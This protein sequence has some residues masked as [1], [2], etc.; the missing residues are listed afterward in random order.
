V[1]TDR[2]IEVLAGRY[3][4]EAELGRGATGAVWVAADDLLKRTVAVKVL[5]PA[6]ADDP[7]S[8]ELLLRH[9]GAAAGASGPGLARLLDSGS[10]RGVTYL[11]RE[12]IPGES[13]RA[14]LRR[15]GPLEPADA[16]RSVVQALE[17]LA[18]AHAAGVLH[19][20]IGPENVIR[21]PSGDTR[22]TDLGIGAGVTA[23]YP[24]SEAV[25]ILGMPVPAPEQTDGRPVDARTDVF[26]AGALLFEL[27]TG[28]PPSELPPRRLGS[29]TTAELATA[30]RR[31][32]A[33]D[34]DDRFDGAQAFADALRAAPEASAPPSPPRD[35]DGAGLRTWLAVPLIVVALATVAVAAGLWLG[36]LELGGPLGV[37]ASRGSPTPSRPPAALVEVVLPIA[38]ASAHDPFGDGG[39]NDA[40]VPLAID[41][42]PATSWRSENYFDPTMNNKPGVG[43]LFDLG[44]TRSVTGFR[45]QTPYPGFGFGIAV[46]DDPEVLASTVSTG[47]TAEPAMRRTIDPARGRYVLLWATSV[48][49]A[50]DGDR[51]VV[52]EFE[53]I[54]T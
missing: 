21:D 47:F 19:L 35:A 29:G 39:E 54:G 33:P 9:A 34:P 44:T 41:G 43:L 15:D 11:V 40:A 50:G 2:P 4:L 26:L 12:H 14:V 28:G 38:H 27:L 52:A 49:D 5:R 25:S 36:R 7:R 18:A 24:P 8:L 20:D 37:R 17:G 45:L 32:L 10:E 13:L 16:V 53:V 3:V 31:A 6:L 51:A 48:V 22:L 1:R 46:G 23:A 42:D 30:V